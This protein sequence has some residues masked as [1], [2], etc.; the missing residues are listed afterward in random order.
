MNL[1]EQYIRPAVLAVGLVMALASTC[2]A[3]GTG[4]TYWLVGNEHAVWL[5]R[6][7]EGKFDVLVKPTGKAWKDVERD[8]SGGPFGGV[9]VG[10][11]APQSLGHV[12]QDSPWS[13]IQL[14]QP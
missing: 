12:V 11:H 13:Q 14:P 7:A 2:G 8:V 4:K 1:R 6:A 3:S 10:K 5:V 9:A